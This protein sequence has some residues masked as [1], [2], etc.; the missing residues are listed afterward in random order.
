MY[1]T[2]DSSYNPHAEEYADMYAQA[3]ALLVDGKYDSATEA[4]EQISAYEDAA[5]QA[6][7]SQYQKAM[8]CL[9]GIGAKV[10]TSIYD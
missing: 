3:E 9:D 4:F 5:E 7:E 2:L 1:K 6:K 8:G 10:V